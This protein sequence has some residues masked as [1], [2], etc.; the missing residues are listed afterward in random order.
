MNWKLKMLKIDKRLFYTLKFIYI[1]VKYD[2]L[3]EY[4]T[5]FWFA[6]FI[7]EYQQEFQ[8]NIGNVNICGFLLLTTE[9]IGKLKHLQH[10][11][12]T[13]DGLM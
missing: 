8:S 13:I 6:V 9:P 1:F 12:L 5:P 7:K 4:L 11:L 2:L 10:R 3:T